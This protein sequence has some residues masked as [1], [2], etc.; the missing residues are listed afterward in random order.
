MSK[1]AAKALA[2][3][4]RIHALTVGIQAE[5]LGYGVANAYRAAFGQPPCHGQGDFTQAAEICHQ[6]A[7]QLAQVKKELEDGDV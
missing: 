5:L 3:I 1:E 4:Y 6:L 2:E 7:E